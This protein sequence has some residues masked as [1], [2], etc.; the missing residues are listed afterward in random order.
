MAS[1]SIELMTTDKTQNGASYGHFEI[2]IFAGL[3]EDI[4]SVFKETRERVQCSLQ[5]IPP[6]KRYQKMPVEFL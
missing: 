4:N 2:K 1:I 5:S 3:D 6:E